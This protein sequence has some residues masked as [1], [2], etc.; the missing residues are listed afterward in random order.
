MSMRYKGGVISAT[1][2]TISQTSAPGIWTLQQQFQNA[3]N[4][5]TPYDPY[6]EYVSMLLPGNGTN[7]AQNNTFLDSS[8]NTFSITRNGN[9]TQGTFSPYGSNWSN[10][11]DGS[12]DGLLTPSS[13]AFAF[14]TGDY[15]IEFFCNIQNQTSGSSTV[16]AIPDGLGD[17]MLIYV[18]NNLFVYSPGITTFNSGVAVT[19]TWA[20]IA[21]TR[22]SGTLRLFVNGALTN[23]ASDSKSWGTT[24]VNIGYSSVYNY[25]AIGYISNVRIL[26]GTA[27]YT[28]A[29]TPPTAPLTAITNTSLLTCQS[30][31]FIDNSTNAF[32][33]T[34]NG[35]VSVQRFSPFSPTAPYAAGTDGGSGYFDGSGDYLKPTVAT[36]SEIGTGDFSISFWVYATAADP[37]SQIIADTAYNGGGFSNGWVFQ[38]NSATGFSFYIGGASSGN[39][40]TASGV[41]LRNSW[42]YIEVSRS[43]STGYLF[44]NG[45]LITSATRAQNGSS[46]LTAAIGSQQ[47]G[48]STVNSPYFAGY[49]A[50]FRIIKSVG[51][52]TAY[53]PPTAPLTA[54]TN[55]SL[56]L[57]YTNAGIL[58]NAEMNN[59]ETVG[60]A[61][62]STA[63]SKF[64]GGSIAFD[65]TGDA[66]A[67]PANVNLAVGSGDFT[68]E[69][70]VYGANNGS[71][72]GGSYPRLFA[73]GT[74][75]TLGCFEC[76]NAAGT[77]YI[78]MNN[79]SAITFTASTL[80]NSTWNHFAIAR[81]GSSVKAFVNGTQVGAV[82]NSVNLNLAATTQSWI[83]AI[84]AS[85]GNFNGYIDDLRITKGYARYTA[86]FTAPTAPFPDN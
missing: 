37:S 25:F 62:I 14:G 86:N 18:S 35:D 83:G 71:I 75:Q 44:V 17:S 69:M 30:N 52:T 1:P 11:F 38:I 36:P 33:I 73:L 16:L 51:N 13:A 40:L 85:A 58:D 10:Y 12:G 42:N 2:P 78:E 29:F 54:I 77:M 8:T 46:G 43:G 24:S 48:G 65:G 32:T 41:N 19:N 70:W 34:R 31:R 3:G 15:T 82:T 20:H 27:L 49:I 9:T 50:D 59:L 26:K 81:S 76:Y 60:N 28:S 64:G 57:N 72:V 68:L 67:L 23:T 55:T 80:L 22:A 21:L 61:Q 53:T 74:A 66:L 45:A 4:W 79:G 63:Q 39:A 47:N 84:S 56:L 5:P 6:F 7:G